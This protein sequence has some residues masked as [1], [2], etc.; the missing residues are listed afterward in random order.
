MYLEMNAFGGRGGRHR[1]LAFMMFRLDALYK[2][3]QRQKGLDALQVVVSCFTSTAD[4]LSLSLIRRLTF[5]CLPRPCL[6]VV[7][8]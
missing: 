3:M 2:F 6:F 8:P 1:A 7:S 4:L 5:L